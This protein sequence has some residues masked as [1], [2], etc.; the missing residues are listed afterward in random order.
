MNEPRSFEK[1]GSFQVEQLAQRD[2]SAAETPSPEEAAAR[3]SAT[4]LKIPYID[5]RRYDVH[6]NTVKLIHEVQARRFRALVLQDCED[7]FLVGV[8]DPWDLRSQDEIASILKRPID[9]AVIT[10]EQ[11]LDTIDR[12]YRKT[13]Q[14]GLYAKE[15]GRDVD[16]QDKVVD[17]DLALPGTAIDDADAPVVK[18]L[19]TIF[20]DAARVNASDIHFEPQEKTMVVRFRIDGVL[21]PQIETDLRIAPTL[22]VRLKLLAGMD[23]AE[24]RMPQ[25]GRFTVKSAASRFDIRMSTMP[26]QFGESVVLR[27]LRQDSERLTLAQI[28]P[29]RARAVFEK[30]LSS[31]HGI[32]LVTGPTGSG[33]STTL[34]AALER[35]NKPEVKILTCEDPVEYRIPGINQVQVN[36]KID[37]SFA[38]VLR[39]FLRQDPDILLV[40]EIR[41]SETAEIAARAA[42]TGH[43]VLS[44]LHTNDAPSAA[45]RLLDLQV[46]TYLI[47]SSLLAVVSQ[48]L[49]R[50]VCNNCAVPA[51]P[52]PEDLEWFKRHVTADELSLAR[53]RRGKGCV[54]CNGMGFSGRRGVFEVV[55]MTSELA[56][57]LQRESPVQFEALARQ[58]VGRY[59]I[60]RNAFE[61][62]LAGETT[63]SEAITIT[64]RGD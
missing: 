47:A 23:I 9:L 22:A 14:I 52:A 5:L 36:E 43:L 2:N 24:R 53:F 62:V 4:R 13:E 16:V 63:V 6:P 58:Q 41:D 20:D 57:A 25:D 42:M 61:M 7:T 46:P 54:R 12:V 18:L 35:L 17:I 37:L 31:P 40:G 21:H 1:T 3:A 8:V 29:R 39:S 32:V 10:N 48:R 60:E 45:L 30:A 26:T 59:T 34:Y 50:L 11:L 56:V 27:L 64:L 55:E 15:V 49:I 51:L 44:T 33:K 38:R 19:Q 28:M